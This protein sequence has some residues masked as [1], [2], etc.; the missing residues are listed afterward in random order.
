MQLDPANNSQLND[1]F[2]WL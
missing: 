1:T 2:Q